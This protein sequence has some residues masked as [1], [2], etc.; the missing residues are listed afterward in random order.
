MAGV[1]GGAPGYRRFH[2]ASIPRSAAR[3]APVMAGRRSSR[4]T[5]PRDLAVSVTTARVACS[6]CGPIIVPFGAVELVATDDAIWYQFQCRSCGRANTVTTAPRATD[7]LVLSGIRIHLVPTPREVEE[8][9]VSRPWSAA[10]I[11]Q[12]LA[13]IAA[14]GP[15]GSERGDDDDDDGP[16]PDGSGLG[17]P[18][19]DGAVPTSGPDQD[20]IDRGPATP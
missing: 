15:Q 2:D 17:E 13:E 6:A 10:E 16:V 11:D 5:D 18:L 19:S 14:I 12:L 4:R 7:L 9:H 8:H 3:I 1:T 20:R